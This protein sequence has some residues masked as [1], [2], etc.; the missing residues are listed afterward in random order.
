MWNHKKNTASTETI[1]FFIPVYY[2]PT[3]IKGWYNICIFSCWY[4]FLENACCP[5]CILY[6]P[7][8]PHKSATMENHFC[9]LFVTHN[10]NTQIKKKSMWKIFEINRSLFFVYPPI[11]YFL[12]TKVIVSTHS[13]H[14]FTSPK[15]YNFFS[16]IF[17]FLH[18]IPNYLFFEVN[19]FTAILA[20]D[21]FHVL[22]PTTQQ[23]IILAQLTIF[24]RAY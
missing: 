7:A 13:Y 20:L 16:Y 5:C 3:Q 19:H 17:F 1:F 6:F 2:L 15:H 9:V 23:I 8:Y 21:I 22:L 10:G 18:I 24:R 12:C 11:I 14:K 4:F